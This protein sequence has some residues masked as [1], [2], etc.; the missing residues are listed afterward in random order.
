MRIGG[1]AG[2]G[3]LLAV[4][5]DEG[6]IDRDFSG[7]RWDVAVEPAGEAIEAE[8]GVKDEQKRQ[9]AADRVRA[10]DAEVLRLIDQR[11]A[12]GETGATAYWLRA[13][14]GWGDLM[15]VLHRDQKHPVIG[16][17]VEMPDQLGIHR[18][19][20]RTDFRWLGFSRYGF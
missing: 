13:R 17:M 8:R 5:V 12:D 15:E 6:T 7:R 9:V 3:R 14:L 10:D 18:L 20:A 11:V 16:R 1:S 4:Q 2:H 19:Y